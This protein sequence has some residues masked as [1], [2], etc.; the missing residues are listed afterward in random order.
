[1]EAASMPFKQVR[2]TLLPGSASVRA[3][4]LIVSD[5]RRSLDF[6]AGTIGLD[7]LQSP[8]K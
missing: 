8:G 4:G 5:L 6:Y 7:V 3:A 2:P 1:M